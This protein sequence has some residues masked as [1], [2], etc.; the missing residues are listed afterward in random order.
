VNRENN[1]LSDLISISAHYDPTTLIS[2]NGELIQILEVRGF[3]KRF[4]KNVQLNLR[5]EV[6]GVLKSLLSENIMFY[7]YVKRDYRK[8]DLLSDFSLEL[9]KNNHEM[10]IKANELDSN[11]MNTLYIA[12][13]HMGAKVCLSK[14]NILHHVFFSRIKSLFTE[15]LEKC[16]SEISEVSFE[17]LKKLE[18]YGVGLLS[19]VEKDNKLISQPLSFIHYL[20]SCQEV[21][22]EV[23]KVDFA[24]LLSFNLKTKK[25]YNTC[26]LIR[27]DAITIDYEGNLQVRQSH[28]KS[29]YMSMLTFKSGYNLPIKYTDQILTLNQRMVITET[30]K[31]S[32][33]ESFEK[34]L[35]LDKKNYEVLKME[36]GL[37]MASFL[38]KSIDKVVKSQISLKI[39]GSSHSELSAN[40]I[41]TTNLLYKIGMSFI[42]E[43]FYM[44]GS[45]FSILPGNSQMLRRE[46]MTVMEQ[47]SIFTSI[48]P[49]CLGGYNGSIWG[50]PVTIFRTTDNLPFFFNF[51]NSKNLGHTIVVGK[52]EYGLNK[53][54]S[55]LISASF[56]FDVKIIDLFSSDKDMSALYE[57]LNLDKS[58]DFL[59]VNLIKMIDYSVEEF[60]KILKLLLLKDQV[61][62]EELNKQME[63]LC[64]G[65]IEVLK[66]NND[67]SLT[68]SEISKLITLKIMNSDIQNRFLSFFTKEFYFKFFNG[69]LAIEKTFFKC[70]ISEILPDCKYKS[71]AI[72][73]LSLF[74]LKKI[75][76]EFDESN[77]TPIIINV[78]SDLLLLSES[79]HT[80][81][82]SVLEN[83]AKRHIVVILNCSDR[84]TLYKIKNLN[85][86]IEQAFAVKIFL[87]DKFVDKEF[88]NIFCLSHVEINKIKMYTPSENIFLMKQDDHSVTCSFKALNNI[89][90]K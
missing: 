59:S 21:E 14:K 65:I 43:D 39:I 45:F 69:D 83:L 24:K 53:L 80:D 81:I 5:D 75:V 34:Q 72:A 47:S 88:K 44:M 37:E 48:Q 18:K 11:L 85:E 71:Q 4:D 77:V 73:I 79:Y 49:K 76:S 64:S 63:E 46:F 31:L 58:Q 89:N 28:L 42:T 68:V 27:D 30:I 66:C 10:W 8:L 60:Y 40:L 20:I 50:E 36:L 82:I 6:R 23:K 32:T 56:K 74:T 38:L 52:E 3:S 54:V 87:S 62:S 15:T 22:V 61:V 90:I 35:K 19:I 9:P 78:S 33:S 86:L 7:L 17:I 41:Q 16:I 55:F 13:V 1:C 25:A 67:I 84:T 26:E 29:H 51:H 70:K 57:S 12:V 2:K